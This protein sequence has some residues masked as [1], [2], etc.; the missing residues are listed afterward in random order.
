MRTYTV[1]AG[2]TLS[3]IAKEFGT[4]VSNLQT[5]N[6]IS[7]PNLI[8]VNMILQIE[9]D[10]TVNKTKLD[11]SIR[12]LI[13]YIESKK[14]SKLLSPEQRDNITDI[15]KTAV[16][17]Y[18]LNDL[19][20]IAYIL[21]TIF[22][23]TDRTF[24]PIEEYGKG[25]N[26]A[27]GIPHKN[28]GKIYYGRGY[29]Q[30]TWYDNYDRFNTILK[31]KGYK[32]IDLINK[33]EQAC[34]HDIAKHIAII[35]MQKGKFTGRRLD[36]YFDSSKSDWYNARRIINGIDKAVIIKDIAIEFYNELKQ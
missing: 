9:D 21:A 36:D 22:W 28:T 20:E 33:P 31:L 1:K 16:N 6:N 35:G 11:T 27:Y 19:R 32:N 34:T 15:I 5:I 25:R 14:L 30:I 24:K 29:V 8:K 10:F 18:G 7:N 17:E 13:S 23:E 26:K 4:T 12:R 3:K 2:D